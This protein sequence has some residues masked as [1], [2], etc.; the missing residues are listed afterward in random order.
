MVL[1]TL[2]T[3]TTVAAQPGTDGEAIAPTAEA[4][5]VRSAP[6]R[7]LSPRPVPDYDGRP[8]PAPTPGERLLWI[9]RVLFFP[10][11]VVSELL[12]RRPLD[13]LF[14]L[15]ESG[16]AA[17][18]L[19]LFTFGTGGRVALVPTFLI[20]FGRQPSVGLYFRANDVG[21]PAHRLRAHFATW[22]PDWLSGT[23]AERLVPA[24]ERLEVELRLEATRRPDG[25]Y[26]GTGGQSIDRASTYQLR[27]L[28]GT[29]ELT[30]EPFRN[31]TVRLFAGVEEV[32]FSDD[33]TI[34]T[35]VEQRVADGALSALPP[36]Y[37][38][39]YFAYRHGAEVVFETRRPRPSNTSGVHL[40]A[41]AQHA[42]DLAHP[43][44][45][46]WATWGGSIGGYLDVT[47]AAHVAS[48]TLSM[49]MTRAITGEIPF[50]ELVSL[51][52]SGPMRG[53]RTDRLIG[54]SAA[55]AVFEWSWPVWV[56]LDGFVHFAVGNTFDGDFEG[57]SAGNMR[58]SFGFGLSAVRTLDHAFDLAIGWGTDTFD[59]GPN[60]VS[61]RLTGGATRNF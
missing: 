53:F 58:M 14:R 50:T 46:Q 13:A 35:S 51:S 25:L 11:W 39:G 31:S 61:F 54:Q 47:G 20:D 12:V 1:T 34:G 17:D 43:L 21:H 23:V 8:E 15:A 42:V 48:L 41:H 32:R 6:D 26:F 37:E 56:F 10:L 45:R 16:S 28:A 36:G 44:A 7:P 24:H 59:D 29:L 18:P 60:V 9:P 27:V 4:R 5:T 30:A 38:D 57:L 2:T 55:A 49:S 40:G 52:G 33:V 22:G 3:T 19:S